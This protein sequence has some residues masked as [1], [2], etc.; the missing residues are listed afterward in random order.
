MPDIIEQIREFEDF[1]KSDRNIE[2]RAKTCEKHLIIDFAELIKFSDDLG[3]Q[4]LENP[5]ETLKAF[6]KAT[7]RIR[8]DDEKEIKVR[9]TSVD[10]IPS[11]NIRIR[12]V[13]VSDYGKFKVV[14]GVIKHISDIKGETISIRFEC[15][16][17]GTILNVLQQRFQSKR[18]PTRC[19]CGRRGKFVELDQEKIDSQKMVI[20]EDF[21]SIEGT[22]QP[23]R[24]NIV[25][26]YGLCSRELERYNNLGAR[27]AITGIILPKPVIERGKIT[28]ELE[29][30]IEANYIK[31]LEDKYKEITI[32]EE[33]KKNIKK[34]SKRDDLF[35]VLTKSLAPHIAGHEDVKKAIVLQLFGGVEHLTPRKRD[36]GIFHILLVGDPATAKTKLAKSIEPIAIKYRY[37]AGVRA[38]KAGMTAMVIKDDFLGTWGVEAGAIVLANGGIC[39]ADE[40]DKMTTEDREALYEQ[41][42]DQQ[43]TIDKANIHATLIAKT[44]LLAIANWKGQRFNPN[45]DIYS[46]INM[47]DPLISR[48]DLYFCFYDKPE[49]KKDKKVI[50]HILDIQEIETEII[51]PEFFRKYVIHAK[52][53]TPKL[54]VELKKKIRDVYVDIRKRSGNQLDRMIITITARQGDAFRRLSEASARMHLRD[55]IEE[56]VNIAKELIMKSLESVAFDVEAG[57]TDIDRIEIGISSK[58]QSMIHNIRVE[59]DRL[60][61]LFGKIVPIDELARIF[62][63]KE[64]EFEETLN[65]LIKAGDYFEP[66]RGF[67][68]RL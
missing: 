13:R 26:Q 45:E 49:E 35:D 30:Y 12:D 21:E 63:D 33:D 20:E 29:P 14:T 61:N 41:M 17:C 56:D 62:K 55:V 51:E 53:F 18:E 25:L 37:T 47:P 46:Q 52:E 4:L 28:N 66:R 43:F 68:Q 57:K 22:Q 2:F 16:V 31:S 36:R 1:I 10:K 59:Y 64:I 24:M 39:V 38:S 9:F 23:R 8:D 44:S 65:K 54:S 15:P 67:I 5:E 50:E 6:D 58:A 60:E 34:L 11:C 27:V 48:F 40:L 42:E 3:T 7:E 19:G 32:T